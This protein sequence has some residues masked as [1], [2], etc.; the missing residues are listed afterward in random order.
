MRAKLL[1]LS[2]VLVAALPDGAFTA[3]EGHDERLFKAEVIV[4][5]TGEKERARGFREGLKEIFVKLAGDASLESSDKLAPFL[6]DASAYIRDYSYED[7]MKHLPIRDEQGTRDR[8]HF[9]RL[10]ADAA[11]IEAAM[12]EAGLRIWDDRPPID[13]LLTVKDF[14]LSYLVAAEANGES[15]AATYLGYSVASSR[16]QGYEMREVLKSI[17]SRRGLTLN[18]PAP[19]ALAKLS[20]PGGARAFGAAGARYRASIGVLPSGYWTLQARAWT[21]SAAGAYADN[22]ACFSFEISEVSFDTALRHSIDAFAA[23]LRD[24]K[25]ALSC[26]GEKL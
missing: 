9:L 23:W 13:V 19:A 25:N 2:L 26:G 20:E 1:V 12:N 11:K 5:G 6:N 17:A 10:T 24:D 3:G 21:L 18:L 16:Y 14:K 7:R 4:T 15:S 8:P 22:P